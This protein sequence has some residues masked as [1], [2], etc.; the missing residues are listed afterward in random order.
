MK[1]PTNLHADIDTDCF[2][3]LKCVFSK[4]RKF[5]VD[6]N[7]IQWIPSFNHI[8]HS[9]ESY[10]RRKPII[11]YLIYGNVYRIIQMKIVCVVFSNVFILKSIRNMKY[12]TSYVI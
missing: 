2:A 4:G 5:D 6:V 12:L 8:H 10:E 1:L 11:A 7:P 3:K 9:M